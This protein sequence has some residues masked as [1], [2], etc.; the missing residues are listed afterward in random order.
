MKRIRITVGDQGF[1]SVEPLKE[2]KSF[3][4]YHKLL[5]EQAETLICAIAMNSQG[6]LLWISVRLSP[7]DT[8]I[9]SAAIIDTGSVTLMSNTDDLKSLLLIT[10]RT[11]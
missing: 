6:D 11:P 4:N 2:M 3:R 9:I 5:H 7:L 8:T 10:A 1:K